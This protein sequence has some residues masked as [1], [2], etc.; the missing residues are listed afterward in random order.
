MHRPSPAAA[1]VALAA[2][3][4]PAA[5]AED[6]IV[7]LDTLLGAARVV[8][9]QL[10]PDGRRVAFLRGGEG[11]ATQI[12]V[13]PVDGGEAR[14]LARDRAQWPAHGVQNL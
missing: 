10:S 8:A 7:P 2:L 4:A 9:P 3:V 6:P 13:M 11:K 12:A 5:A 1:L 14:V